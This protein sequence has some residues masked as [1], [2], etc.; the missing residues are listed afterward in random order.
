MASPATDAVGWRAP[1]FID[2]AWLTGVARS[3]MTEERLITWSL[4]N[5]Q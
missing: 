5:P 3:E 2:G 4:E 1:L